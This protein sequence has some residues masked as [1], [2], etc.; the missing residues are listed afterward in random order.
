MRM[1]ETL[2]DVPRLGRFTSVRHLSLAR[3]GPYAVRPANSS[4]DNRETIT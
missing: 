2:N 3:S 1:I 4:D